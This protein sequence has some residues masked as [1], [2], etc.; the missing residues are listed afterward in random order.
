MVT[1][2]AGSNGISG[3][4]DGTASAARF[5][6]PL[7]MAV[8]SAANVYLADYYNGTI[9]EI[10]P[11]GTVTTLAGSASAGSGDGANATARFNFPSS[12]ALDSSSNLYVADS[13][14]STIR[15]ITPN[16][17]VTTFAGSPGVFGS[18][19]NSGTNAV[20]NGPRSVA[21]DSANNV[22]VA[23][24]LNHTIRKI[25]PLGAV[26]TFAGSAG[27]PGTVDGQ[28]T[29]AQFGG[30]QGIAVD[31]SN[32]V[33]VADTLNHTIRV[34]TPAGSV[35][36][37]AGLAGS[38][39]SAD[40]T[41]SAARFNSPQGVAVDASGNVYVADFLNHEIREI[42]PAGSVST[43]AGLAGVWGSADGTNNTARFF[44]PQ[45]V[46]V[47]ANGYVYVSDS[48]NQT[49]RV[50]VPSGTNWIVTTAAGQAGAAGFANGSGMA[51]RF[52]YPAGLAFD[53]S[54]N[55]YLADAANNTVRLQG[56]LS[57]PLFISSVSIV[58]RP[59]SAIV[60]WTTT[61]P[62]SSQVAYGLTPA[63]GSLTVLDPTLV[64]NHAA[65]LTGLTSNSL[66]Y[67]QIS[68]ATIATTATTNGTFSA[69]ADIIMQ[70]PQAVYAG[71][72]VADSVVTDNFS[73]VYKYA[74]VAP[75]ASAATATFAPTIVTPG[76]YDVYIW[77]AEGS[78][79]S[80]YAPV[81]IGYQGGS[82]STTI[83]ETLPGGGWQLLAGDKPFAAGTTGFVRLGNS[84]TDSNKVVI[85]DAVMFV[86][87]AGQDL[88]VNGNVPAWWLNLYFGTN[89]V[90][91]SAIAANG[92]TLLS[93]YILGLSPIDPNSVLNFNV[94]PIHNGFKAVFSPFM[95]DRTYQLQVATNLANPAWT[96]VSNTTAIQTNGQG[97]IMVTNIVGTPV[98][99]RLSVSLNQ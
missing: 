59:S 90:S 86:Y 23:D 47:D 37:L 64:T 27:N 24:A 36:T 81:T 78:N 75:P 34:I 29:N 83:N 72:W 67:F 6:G 69:N 68:S 92:Y 41:N 2:I 66:Y 17:Q 38:F 48:G 16:G 95:G 97:L 31:S 3:S 42:T 77:Y 43:L 87:T 56:L 32:N 60:Y 13:A 8:D 99:Y 94:N 33:Y 63:Y 93:D 70:S 28:G 4:A 45:N 54:D 57:L 82:Y 15:K 1:T 61:A 11:G 20:L 73:P 39:G 65:L 98:F 53:H 62:S 76:Q 46:A 58:P 18:L 91:S 21:I 71:V 84:A 5:N 49:V 51:A 55:A 96:T 26:S 89:A 85:A 30:P 88:P 10:T 79:R 44:E 80:M 74:N 35:S 12:V 50:L 52:N 9:R 14:N 7:G 22:Y 19:D 40:G 25:T